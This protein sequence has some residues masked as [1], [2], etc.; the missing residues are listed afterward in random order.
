V[1]DDKDHVDLVLREALVTR[2]A[3]V[4]PEASEALIH[5]VE[6]GPHDRNAG[7]FGPQSLSW[8]INRG[9]ALFLGAGR[10]ALLQLAHPWVATA[11]EQHSSLMARPIARFHS[12]FRIVF[13]MIFGSLDQ[14]TAAARHLYTLHTRIQGELTEDAGGHSR[15]AHYEANEIGALRWVF[16]TLVESAVRAHDCVL[17]PL[18]PSD[19]EAY[20][21]ESKTLAAL[22]GLPALALPGDWNNF[23][24]YCREMEQSGAL[25]VTTTARGMAQKLLKGAGS[26]IKPPG[27][28]QAL[29]VEEL[30]ERFR[31]EFGLK[32]G[33]AEQRAA[34]SARRWLPRIYRTLPESIRF[35]GPWHEAQARLRGRRVGLLTRASNRFWIGQT[36]L[37]FAR[38]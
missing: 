26:W 17:P 9:S 6:R 36:A 29:T 11:L 10:A 3:L 13:T 35:V 28:Y 38:L 7:I 20:Y 8:R 15:G 30:P 12:T 1:A 23:L 5:S 37:P 18:T 32:F 33:D 31:D 27:W 4:S 2:E 21:A 14:A 16:A 19:L 25:G 22:F 24:I 34:A